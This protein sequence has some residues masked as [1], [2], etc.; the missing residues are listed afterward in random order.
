[1]LCELHK[2][3]VYIKSLRTLGDL[4]QTNEYCTCVALTFNIVVYIYIHGH[5]V[6]DFDWSAMP[7]FAIEV[8]AN[9]YAI[10]SAF[11]AWLG[12]GR[13]GPHAGHSDFFNVAHV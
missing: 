9:C 8:S 3:T 13:A 1:M 2:S 6:Y 4:M 12:Q 5:C 7:F 11:V 10:K